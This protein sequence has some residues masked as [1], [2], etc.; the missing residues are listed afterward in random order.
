MVKFIL[1]IVTSNILLAFGF[2]STISNAEEPTVSQRCTLG[3]CEIFMIDIA[4]VVVRSESGVTVPVGSNNPSIVVID[5]G[6]K[7]NEARC[8]KS[9][10]VP[11]PVRQ[12]LLASMRRVTAAMKSAP[13]VAFNPSDQILMLMY[14]TI[15]KQTLGF[16]RCP[17]NK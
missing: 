5:A 1:S 11:A 7:R 17:E 9:I 8:S 6:A 12:G 16:S 3:M 4:R 15:M 13:P 2:V 10:F 14:A